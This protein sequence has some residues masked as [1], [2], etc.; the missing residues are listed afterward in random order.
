MDSGRAM[1]WGLVEDSSAPTTLIHGASAAAPIATEVLI[2][3]WVAHRLAIVLRVIV[4][5]A[6]ASIALVAA[7]VRAGAGVVSM[8]RCLRVPPVVVLLCHSHG[9]LG[10]SRLV[11]L[12]IAVAGKAK[13]QVRL[14][15]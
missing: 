4:A 15:A 7:S 6:A 8:A 3:G 1:A 10:N 12:A 13:S 2:I 9:V 14:V 5:R 11:H